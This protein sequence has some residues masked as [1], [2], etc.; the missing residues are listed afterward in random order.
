MRISDDIPDNEMG[1]DLPD[2]IKR[3]REL[4][5]KKPSGPFVPPP[6]TVVKGNVQNVSLNT[7]AAGLPNPPVFNTENFKPLLPSRQEV[8]Q[9]KEEPEESLVEKPQASK[10]SNEF[11][12][13]RPSFP[14]EK[15]GPEWFRIDFPSNLVPYDVDEIFVRKF[16]VN[17]LESIYNSI[18]TENHA[19]YLDALDHCISFDIRELTVPD[20]IYLQYILRMSSYTRSPYT[21]EY[22]S[23]YGNERTETIS[24]R[25]LKVV[26]LDMSRAEYAEW[27]QKG[28][29]F[30]TVRDSE[31]IIEYE[32]TK[33]D[34]SPRPDAW[35]QQNAQ[36]IYIP[37]NDPNA[38]RSMEAKIDMLRSSNNIDILTDIQE[39]AQ[40]S[41][42]GVIESLEI[43]DA[44]FKPEEAITFLRNS[45]Q[46]LRQFV[47]QITNDNKDNLSEAVMAGSLHLA[48]Q[49]EALDTEADDIARHLEEK[50]IYL[51]KKE[52]IAL[53]SISA[54][55]MFPANYLAQR[56]KSK[57]DAA[58][59]TEGSV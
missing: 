6:K 3:I 49:A 48:E 14:K 36:Y 10:P 43:A 13:S 46:Q 24:Q 51:P 8:A 18:E 39:F 12:K 23:R 45:A 9:P 1:T 32:S 38:N 55:D 33:G 20:F 22:T 27:K 30:P 42:H 57:V 56:Q 29:A 58:P 40:R 21:I 4:Q 52:T 37:T 34:N 19:G 5:Q 44:D 53:R 54:M 59:S 47:I 41:E 50:R 16:N 31:Y 17:D 26:Y 35:I 15:L 2:H 25:N 7:N 28:I 11:I